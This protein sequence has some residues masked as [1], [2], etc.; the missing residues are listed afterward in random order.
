MAVGDGMEVASRVVARDQMLAGCY[1]HNAYIDESL[2][3][4]G[5]GNR[6]SRP[7]LRQLLSQD[8]VFLLQLLDPLALTISPSFQHLDVRGGIH[9]S[10]DRRLHT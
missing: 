4:S 1:L 3:R 8:I 10:N 5:N 7:E 9:P 6:D 2:W